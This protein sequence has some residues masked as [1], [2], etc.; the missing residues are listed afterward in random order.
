VC[1]SDLIE[2]QLGPTKLK[3]ILGGETSIRVFMR[4]QSDLLKEIFDVTA[5]E[6]GLNFNLDHAE[7]V[8][9]IAKMKDKEDIAR[10]LKNL[11]GMTSARNYELGWRGYSTK[12]KSLMNNIYQGKDVDKN[13]QE[14]NDLTKSV[15]PEV[16]GKDAYKMVDNKIVPTE[17]FNFTY[18]PEKAFR[19]YFTELTSTPKSLDVLKSQ[20][21]R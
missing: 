11:I 5:L 1:S 17:N 20:Y 7:G 16:K 15:Y 2:K 8:A 21:E 6:P 4:K 9:E 14:L 3:E 19:Q 10:G 18:E 12:R 13:I